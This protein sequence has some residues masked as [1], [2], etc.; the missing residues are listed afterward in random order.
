MAPRKH[1]LN[2]SKFEA[3]HRLFHRSM[4][5]VCARSI[6]RSAIISTRS[7]KLSLNRRYQRTQRM[8]IS[9]SKWRPLKRSS[10]LN[11]LGQLH[12]RLICR[13]YA[14]LPLFAPE[15]SRP[16]CRRN[17]MA[18]RHAPQ[19][20]RN[21]IQCMWPVNACASA[22]TYLGW[23]LAASLPLGRTSSSRVIGDPPEDAMARAVRSE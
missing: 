1:C 22:I 7:L 16:V 15:P 8:M 17:G 23:I 4:I 3:Q 13:E 9:R 5:V 10:M 18:R 21:P 20:H 11:M 12:R 14:P 6:P 2:S 19:S